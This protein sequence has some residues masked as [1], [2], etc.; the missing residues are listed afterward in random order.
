MSADGLAAAIAARTTS[1]GPGPG[2]LPREPWEIERAIRE[3]RR[4]VNRQISDREH[5]IDGGRFQLR[6]GQS[7][8]RGKKE[9]GGCGAIVASASKR[10]RHCKHAFLRERDLI[11]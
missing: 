11:V 6:P 3:T 8:G 2:R 4:E 1:G 5:P 9:C 7:P 10:C